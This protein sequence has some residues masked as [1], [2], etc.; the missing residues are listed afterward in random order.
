MD[1][2]LEYGFEYCDI[3]KKFQ[4]HLSENRDRYITKL[5]IEPGNSQLVEIRIF[6]LKRGFVLISE[7]TILKNEDKL[8]SGAKE[9]YLKFKENF[10]LINSAE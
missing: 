1:E 6:M 8:Y 9:N 4:M 3:R 7:E 5:E 10:P 2:L